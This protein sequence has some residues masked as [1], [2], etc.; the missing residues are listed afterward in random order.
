[1]QKHECRDYTMQGFVF[2]KFQSG[3]RL[4]KTKTFIPTFYPNPIYPTLYMLI[5]NTQTILWTL[6]TL[7]KIRPSTSIQMHIN[8]RN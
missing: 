2:A 6:R 3:K 4:C 5:D 8:A 1:M 7:A